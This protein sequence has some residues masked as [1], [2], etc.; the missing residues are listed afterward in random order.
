MSPRPPSAD[1]RF[2]WTT[3]AHAGRALLGP[4]SAESVEALLARVGFPAGAGRPGVLDVG[5]G[6]GEILLRAMQRLGARGTGVDPNEA[7]LDERARELGIAGDL[8][9]H[10]CRWADAPAREAPADL[11]I[12]TGA[13]HAFGDLDAALAGLRACVREGGLALVGTGYWRRP[14]AP[15]Y[16]DLLGAV[17]GEMTTLDSTLAAAERAGWRVQARHASTLAEWDE[18]EH[19]YASAMRR[20]V[21]TAGADPD[22]AAFGARIAAWSRGY[23]R[24]GRETLGFATLLLRR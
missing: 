10:A 1:A 24:W 14:P 16:L 17:E 13:T 21:A 2:R 6:K 11:A 8:S 22:A 12:C 5:C 9:L 18:Y 23:E 4:L 15:E 20:W 19:A 3:I 7:F